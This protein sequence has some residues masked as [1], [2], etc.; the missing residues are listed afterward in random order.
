MHRPRFQTHRGQTQS[1]LK[2]VAGTAVADGS[3]DYAAQPGWSVGLVT[4]ASAVTVA[5][6]VLTT[7]TY[8]D[9]L[10]RTQKTVSPSSGTTLYAYHP[11]WAAGARGKLAS[12]TDADGVVVA[13]DYNA[14]GEQ[15]TVT[16]T[17]PVGAGTATQVT[18][19][20][21]D[22]V[23]GAT[24]WGTNLGTCFRTT[25]SIASTGVGAITVAESYRSINGLAG[26]TR[27]FGK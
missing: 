22:V 8:Q 9:T 25:Q 4:H 27:S 11:A 26:G 1:Q 21:R 10:G 7:S 20:T 15:T 17:I 3:Y 12:V 5:P 23:T 6:A 14:E 2:S 18:T 16:R 24:L 19:T 13:Y